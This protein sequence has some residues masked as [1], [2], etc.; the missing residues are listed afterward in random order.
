MIADNVQPRSDLFTASMYWTSFAYQTYINQEKAVGLK[1]R[2]ESRLREQCCKLGEGGL[3]EIPR[4]PVSSLTPETF[5]SIY[6]DDN[7]PVV[8][9]GF[10]SSWPAIK[11]WTPEFFKEHYGN[12]TVPVRVDATSVTRFDFSNMLFGD[13]IDRIVAGSTESATGLENIFNRNKE[14]RDD[15]CLKTLDRYGS[16]PRG[17]TLMSQVLGRMI[18][19]Q[20]FF[21]NPKGCTGWHCSSGINLFVNVYG[22]KKWTM[23]HPK[24]SM[25]MSPVVRNDAYYS[26]SVIDHRKSH[27]EL[28]AEGYDLYTYVPK[29][30]TVTEP[31]DVLFV[32][33]WWW[34]AVDNESI[35]I[36]VATRTLNDIF[37]GHPVNAIMSNLSRPTRETLVTILRTGWGNDKLVDY[38]AGGWGHK[39][40]AVD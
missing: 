24:H 2:A 27:K 3:Y 32:P 40:E 5:Q 1:T 13:L 26:T 9:T 8:L 23:A 36:G 29:Y 15:L 20:L 4:V 35:S 31:G 16:R 28:A 18:S 30:Q 25:W 12:Q 22:R 14:L 38:A 33:Q 34:H 7:T 19:T 37:K 21:S 11:K 39:R 6:L 17:K 10:A